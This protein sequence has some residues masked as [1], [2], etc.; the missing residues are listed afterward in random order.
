MTARAS[1]FLAAAMAWTMTSV[2]GVAQA[3][4][5]TY[6]WGCGNWDGATQP[7]TLWCTDTPKIGTSIE[8]HF[9]GPMYVPRWR[10]S[11]I[12]PF[13]L[14]GLSRTNVGGVAL[15]FPINW[16][17]IG[18]SNCMLWCSAEFFVQI[19]S[20]PNGDRGSL[21]LQIPNNPVL[22][23]VT[24]Y[25]QWYLQYHLGWSGGIEVFYILS[26]GGKMTIGW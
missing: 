2:A 19:W 22:A 3:S 15:P 21:V 26:N 5:T 17:P 20:V 24:L 10:S 1:R 25:H 13:L 9:L 4:Y 23:G 7:A 8:V 14:T 6:G 12:F 11:R 16:G 18:G